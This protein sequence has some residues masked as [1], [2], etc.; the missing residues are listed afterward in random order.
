MGRAQA[1]RG[2]GSAQA[3]HGRLPALSVLALPVLEE[4]QLAGLRLLQK[5]FL[6]LELLSAPICRR[7]YSSSL[8][9]AFLRRSYTLV[10]PLAVAHRRRHRHRRHRRILGRGR[11][12][13]GRRAA[14]HKQLD[15]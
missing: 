2:G 10:Q 4:S 1:G 14:R 15:A 12:E 6:P 13:V 9:N 3:G 11:L 8:V 7:S 5:H